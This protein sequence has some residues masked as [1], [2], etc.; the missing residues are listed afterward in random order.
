MIG[1]DLALLGLLGVA[2]IHLRRSSGYVVKVPGVAND[3]WSGIREPPRS[4][5]LGL[6]RRRSGE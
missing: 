2:F 6:V 1:A 4:W 5:G 3:V